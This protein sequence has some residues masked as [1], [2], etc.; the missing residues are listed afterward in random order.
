MYEPC[1]SSQLQLTAIE[2]KTDS[3][4]FDSF[5]IT[6]SFN[7]PSCESFFLESAQT[8]PNGELHLDD[9]SSA[10]ATCHS[11]VM[12]ATDNHKKASVGRVT[13]SDLRSFLHQT[14]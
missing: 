5:C 4:I 10:M 13:T 2:F 1:K 3:D 9:T 14:V 11:L 8:Q 12:R 7:F 6:N